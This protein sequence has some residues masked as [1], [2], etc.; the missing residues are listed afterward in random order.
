MLRGLPPS[1]ATDLPE[2]RQNLIRLEGKF[3]LA[4]ETIKTRPSTSIGWKNQLDHAEK[5]LAGVQRLLTTPPGDRPFPDGT[6]LS[7]SRERGILD[8]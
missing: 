7:Q 1:L 5:R 2:N 4:V 3:K 6:D 8:D